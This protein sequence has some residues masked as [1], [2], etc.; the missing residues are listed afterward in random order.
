MN[1]PKNLQVTESD[2]KLVLGK[3]V[4][5]LIPFEGFYESAASNR[6]E[7][8]AFGSWWYEH[9]KDQEQPD[10]PDAPEAFWDW[11]AG[12]AHEFQQEVADGYLNEF[13]KEIEGNTGVAMLPD[14][15]SVLIDSPREYNFTT[16]RLFVKVPE[17]AMLELYAQVDKVILAQTVKD[18]FTS[19]DGFISHYDNDVLSDEW[20]DPSNLDHNQWQTLLLAI[21]EQYKINID[22][23]IYI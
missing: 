5:I 17:A 3:T 1:N 20:K 6:A 12:H 19:Y 7:E 10:L 9:N 16:D 8:T 13:I 15:K 2:I 4:E 11:Y 23:L 18:K 21:I 22:E 14:M